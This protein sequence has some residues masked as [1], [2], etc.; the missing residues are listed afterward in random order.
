MILLNVRI[1]FTHITASNAPG[2]DVTN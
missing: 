2:D 1:Y